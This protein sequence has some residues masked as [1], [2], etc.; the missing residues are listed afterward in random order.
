MFFIKS[1][2]IDDFFDYIKALVGTVIESQGNSH[3]HSD[4]WQR[5]IYID[6]L[7]VGTTDFDLSDDK[8][9][10]SIN[11]REKIPLDGVFLTELVYMVILIFGLTKGLEIGV[12]YLPQVLYYV[13]LLCSMLNLIISE[14]MHA[15]LSH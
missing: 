10:K 2:K 8:K 1:K 15:F 5:T 6:T 9:N 14:L 13:F 4:D 12:S 7:G 11:I 3:L